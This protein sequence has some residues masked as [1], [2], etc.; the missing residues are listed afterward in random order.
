MYMFVHVCFLVSCAFTY[1]V[2]SLSA[3]VDHD[4]PYE[5][6]FPHFVSKYKC[7]HERSFAWTLFWH[8]I[9]LAN[10]RTMFV[11]YTP[12]SKLLID[13]HNEVRFLVQSFLCL[14]N[15][16]SVKEGTHFHTHHSKR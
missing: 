13:C 6:Y 1:L 5:L 12:V 8:L 14:I 9:F 11:A 3:N 10:I 2:Y 4:V 16:P 15:G 7:F